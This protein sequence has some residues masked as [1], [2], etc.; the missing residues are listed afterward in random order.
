ML[1]PV[2][3]SITAKISD[4]AV[5]YAR[6][7]MQ[8]RGWTSGYALQPAPASGRVGIGTSLKYLT[9]QNK[10]TKPHIQYELAGKTIPM[11]GGGG[12]N[13]RYANPKSIGTPGFVSIPQPGGGEVRKWR[14]QRWRHPGV[15]ATQFMDKAIHKAIKDAADDLNMM[16]INVLMGKPPE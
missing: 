6:E 5:Q 16:V 3:L 2:P 8:R 4:R 12:R 11:K 1:V 13:F 9:Y 7:D 15:P 14:Q 10:G